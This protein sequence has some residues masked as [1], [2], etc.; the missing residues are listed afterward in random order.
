MSDRAYEEVIDVWN[1]KPQWIVCK[2]SNLHSLSGGG[3]GGVEAPR[4]VGAFFPRPPKNN[5]GEYG[6]PCVVAMFGPGRE[7]NLWRGTG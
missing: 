4:G 7:A 3:G 6:G 5:P 2:I 1:R